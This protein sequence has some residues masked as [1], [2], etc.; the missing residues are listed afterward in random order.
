MA[1]AAIGH[2]VADGNLQYL[3]YNLGNGIRAIRYIDQRRKGK[4]ETRDKLGERSFRKLN[5]LCGCKGFNKRIFSPNLTN[6]IVFY[7]LKC[8]F[9]RNF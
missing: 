8:I 5:I 6:F 7:L 9:R 3:Y 4:R 1:S 2:S